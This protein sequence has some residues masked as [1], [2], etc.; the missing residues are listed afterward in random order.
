MQSTNA[1]QTEAGLIE[2]G[3][4]DHDTGRRRAGDSSIDDH[5]MKSPDPDHIDA[6]NKLF[7]DLELAY[8]NQYKKAFP[9]RE[10]VHVAKKLWQSYLSQY[11]PAQIVEAGRKVIRSQDYLPSVSVVVRACDEGLSLF[12]LSVPRDAYFEACRA[13]SPKVVFPWSHE[14]VYFA[15]K[16]TGWFFLANEAEEK[17]LPV[18][19]YHYSQLCRQVIRGESLQIDHPPA[20]Q[21]NPGEP[22]SSNENKKRLAR[23]RKNLGL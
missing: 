2:S 16:A 5:E 3:T 23:M 17:T 9:T 8:H 18:F 21:D 7:A 11:S 19:E 13:T 10:S 6:L 1:S 22:L 12:G 20:L 15:G 4:A 14:A